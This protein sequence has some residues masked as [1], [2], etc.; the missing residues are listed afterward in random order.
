M[1]S[2]LGMHTML[3]NAFALLNV[4]G[5]LLSLGLLLIFSWGRHL[6]CLLLFLRFKNSFQIW[7][8]FK[9]KNK[10]FNDV[11]RTGCLPH[12]SS[13]TIR[14]SNS[15]KLQSPS[16]GPSP[17]PTNPVPYDS[18]SPESAMNV[19]PNPSSRSDAS[20][21]SPSSPLQPSATSLGTSLAIQRSPLSNSKYNFYFLMRLDSLK[22]PLS[23]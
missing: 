1:E 17:E 5:T 2:N 4:L 11:S 22:G 18:T 9:H 12:R 16:Y 10:Y 14:S 23:A 21:P 6:F 19:H 15:T 8:S 7:S 20:P 3:S 13:T